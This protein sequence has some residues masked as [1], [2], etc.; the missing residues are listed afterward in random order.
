MNTPSCNNSPCR[1]RGGKPASLKRR[2]R[3]IERYSP[4]VKPIARHYQRCSGESFDDLEQVGLMGLLKAAER[5]D[6]N[7]GTPFEAFARP[8]VRGAI[9]HYL[10]DLA[11]SVRVPRRLQEL[12]RQLQKLEQRSRGCSLAQDH[13]KALGLSLHQWQRL[14][15]SLS[16]RRV[17]S[18]DAVT[19]TLAEKGLPDDAISQ[20]RGPDNPM[21]LLSRLD[22]DL[23]VVIERVVLCGW[24]YRQTAKALQVSP[25]TVQRRLHR[26]LGL[27]RQA[28]R[29]ETVRSHPSASA[30]QGC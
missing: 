24:S 18:L 16:M 10:R 25:M 7:S 11:P 2:N 13:R 23:K 17:V 14:V 19:V 1:R 29:P 30:A 27:L 20:G 4:L 22:P 26:G 5:F 15:G 21:D 12:Q 6:S 28:L 3:R 8:H 9:L